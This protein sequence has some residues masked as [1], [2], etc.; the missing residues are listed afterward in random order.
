MVIK[1]VEET[2]VYNGTFL[3]SQMRKFLGTCAKNNQ[4]SYYTQL[5]CN[6]ADSNNILH[7]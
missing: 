5:C 4:F 1:K 3:M 6:T 7:E 2:E